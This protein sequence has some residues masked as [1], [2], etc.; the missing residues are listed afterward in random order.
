[1]IR[2]PALTVVLVLAGTPAATAACRVWCGSPCSQSVHYDEAAIST[3]QH[4]CKN[5]LVG[6]LSVREES[7]RQRQ[8][9][10]VA[11][12]AALPVSASRFDL[13]SSDVV[14]LEL[15]EHLSPGYR[16]AP[17]VLRL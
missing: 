16:Q 14:L 5:A 17:D 13:E 8:V 12:L 9:P 10:S 1:M 11:H 6:T 7:Q 2:V 3:S 4:A 15:R